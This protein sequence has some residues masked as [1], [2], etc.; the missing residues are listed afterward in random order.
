MKIEELAGLMGV[1][2]RDCADFCSGVKAQMDRGLGL[3]AAIHAHVAVF[4]TMLDHV[5]KRQHDPAYAERMKAFVVDAFFPA[6]PA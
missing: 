5:C 3:E 1:S 2:V 6:V 4:Q